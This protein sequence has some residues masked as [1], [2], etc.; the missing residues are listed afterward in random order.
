[1]AL[2]LYL[3]GVSSVVCP[4]NSVI[5]RLS[6][7]LYPVSYFLFPISSFLISLSYF[8]FPLPCLFSLLF[9]IP[10][11]LISLSYFLFP[12]SSLL[13]FLSFSIF[14]LFRYLIYPSKTFIASFDIAQAASY[15]SFVMYPLSKHV[16]K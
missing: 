9:P 15:F 1:M 6:S 5:C 16:I 12:I 10:Y 2:V 8:P 14:C 4:L 13:Y 3:T 7:S 11:F